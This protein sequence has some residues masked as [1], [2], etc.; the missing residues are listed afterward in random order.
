MYPNSSQA[1]AFYGF[2]DFVRGLDPLK[3]SAFFVV[4][5][6]VFEHSLSE[7]GDVLE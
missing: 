5:S 2:E 3:R 6:D 4:S 1:E 7:L